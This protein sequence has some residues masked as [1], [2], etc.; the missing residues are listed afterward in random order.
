MTTIAYKDGVI[1]YDSRMTSGPHI[2]TD[3]YDKHTEYK[4]IH[5]FVAGEC[6]HKEMLFEHFVNKAHGDKPPFD[7]KLIAFAWDGKDLWQCGFTEAFFAY[8]VDYGHD[9]AGS[10]DN[11]AI[12]AMDM[13]ATAEE[14]VRVAAKRDTGT[15]GTIRTFTL[16]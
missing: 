4:G 5:F 2:L 3:E 7:L 11:F 16:E 6:E 15:G 12:A 8:R 1:A 13:G 9:A 10:G 14:A